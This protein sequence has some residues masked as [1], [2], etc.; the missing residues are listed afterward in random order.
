M[1][2]AA[3]GG[4]AGKPRRQRRLPSRLTPTRWAAPP[5][6]AHPLAP[7]PPA[8]R[9]TGGAI[10]NGWRDAGW[11]GSAWKTL[12]NPIVNVSSRLAGLT[13]GSQR[14]MG[15][16]NIEL[17]TDRPLDVN[18]R[19][20]AAVK[21]R[22]PNHAVLV[23][24]MFKGR[25]EWIDI[26]RRCEDTGC[27]GFELN[28]GC[29]YGMCERGMGSALGQEPKVLE[30]LVGWVV[31]A[32]SLPVIP[33][34]TLN[35]ADVRDPGTAAVRGGAH[36]VSPIN[37]IQSLMGVDLDRMVPLPCVVGAS[38]HAVAAI[39]EETCIGCQLCHV[40]C[41]DGAHQCIHLPAAN[42][43]GQQSGDGAAATVRVPWVDESE[44]VGC[45]LC[46][47]VC[48]VEDC[49]TTVE[50]R[51]ADEAESWNERVAAGRGHVSG[52]LAEL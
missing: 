31:D 48:P 22:H 46:A 30:E 14:L 24:L 52:G 2:N 40:A 36:A 42:Q 18:L 32:T 11:G 33:K 26:I 37:T 45:N 23:S 3:G 20:T 49:I 28:F 38:S 6:P 17:I 51:H 44:C 10:A 39:N 15:L 25:D 12:R 50:R 34:L 43:G 47:F 7:P 4:G 21:R 5:P 29:P 35:I 16:N 41:M 8:G 9:A 19:E 13:Y 1:P 27:D